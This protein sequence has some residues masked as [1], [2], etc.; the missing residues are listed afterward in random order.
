MCQILA[1]VT[2]RKRSTVHNCA[3]L[4]RT[5]GQ[6]QGCSPSSTTAALGKRLLCPM[7][8]S[9]GRWDCKRGKMWQAA[10]TSTPVSLPSFSQFP[11]TSL[12][13]LCLPFPKQDSSS[14][15]K[16]VLNLIA[17][18]T[19]REA[20]N[21]GDVLYHCAVIISVS[22]YLCVLGTTVNLSVNHC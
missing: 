1:W 6:S 11:E 7:P 18:S 2:L 10:Q 20:I 13:P 9:T 15:A 22:N 19:G 3:S 5:L 14:L 21:L 8:P 4:E 16:F 12:H 17:G